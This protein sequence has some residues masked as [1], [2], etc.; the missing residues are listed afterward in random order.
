MKPAIV[1]SPNVFALAYSGGQVLLE[2]ALLPTL[3]SE[4]ESFSLFELVTAAWDAYLNDPTPEGWTAFSEVLVAA[5]AENMAG[6]A[7]VEF[8][9][10]WAQAR[11]AGVIPT[12]EVIAMFNPHLEAAGL[13]VKS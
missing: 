12:P 5:D 7:L 2:P 3:T 13:I 1:A 4:S 11:P 10:K 6:E 8:G 9:R